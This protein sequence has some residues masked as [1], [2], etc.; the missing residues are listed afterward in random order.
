MQRI[1]ISYRRADTAAIVG[2]IYD[3]LRAHFGPTAVFMDIDNVPGGADFRE[4]IRSTF[5]QTEVLLVVIGPAWLGPRENSKARIHDRDDPVR[6][7]LE[8]ALR[9]HLS[10]IPILVEGAKMPPAKALPRALR[11]FAFRNA[12]QID[13]GVD[14]SPD[15]DRLIRVIGRIGGAGDPP[16]DARSDASSDASVGDDR[17]GRGML[18]R[19]TTQVLGQIAIL[20][21]LLWL[22]HYLIVIK[23]DLNP[24]YLRLAAAALPALFACWIYWRDRQGVR[25]AI[26]LG[27]G[28]AVL[29]IAGMLTMVAVID[30]TSILPSTV[31]Q[32]QEAAEYLAII[33]L[34]TVVGNR[35]ARVVL[36]IAEK[37]SAAKGQ[38]S[39]TLN[40]TAHR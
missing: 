39:K 25:A 6:F 12:I 13:S 40:L 24:I 23:F 10:V 8:I 21:L 26:K 18:D 11:D 35:L 38:A 32:W 34:A 29:A 19:L 30:R 17:A 5:N 4:H 36:S 27:L 22:A 16:G 9:Q 33:T 3:R 7:E 14:F 28:A 31:G 1:C 15:I 37:R 20:A 2:R